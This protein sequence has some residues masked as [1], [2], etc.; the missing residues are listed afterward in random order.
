MFS[1]NEVCGIITFFLIWFGLVKPSSLSQGR[2]DLVELL[3]KAG[4]D[5]THAAL[6]GKTAAKLAAERGD[7]EVADFL[8]RASRRRCGN[9]IH[10]RVLTRLQ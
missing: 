6:N 1:A 4:A 5:P 7:S 2:Y 3:L 9:R 10:R 8:E